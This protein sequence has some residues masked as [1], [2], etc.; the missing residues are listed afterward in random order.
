M[1]AGCTQRTAPRNIHLFMTIGDLVLHDGETWCLIILLE[2]IVEILAAKIC[3]RG[4]HML[5]GI[6]ITDNLILLSKL[7]P[8]L[9]APNHHFFINYERI[10]Y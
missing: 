6:L 2:Y 10:I 9:M 3:Q 8:G 1:D 4:L 5:L 7:F